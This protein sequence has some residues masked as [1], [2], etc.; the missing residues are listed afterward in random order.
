VEYRVV[1]SL[2]SIT[3]VTSHAAINMCLSVEA[4]VEEDLTVVL[5]RLYNVSLGRGASGGGNMLYDLKVWLAGLIL[6]LP[7]VVLG[8]AWV[9]SSRFYISQNISARQKFLFRVALTAASISTVAYFGYWGWRVCGIYQFILPYSALFILDRL[10]LLGRLLSG[11]AIVCFLAGRGPYRV[12]A[13]LATVWVALQI[14]LHGGV[15]HWA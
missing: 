10:L 12:L 3:V 4:V 7:G 15:I 14:W 11:V 2:K 8:F 1:N 9:K 13:T 6:L 5:R